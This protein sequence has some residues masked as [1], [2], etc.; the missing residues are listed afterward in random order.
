[1]P[2]ENRAIESLMRPNS[3]FLSAAAQNNH[4]KLRPI[5]NWFANQLELP[6]GLKERSHDQTIDLCLKDEETRKQVVQ[7]LAAADLGIVEMDVKEE[8]LAPETSAFRQKF[9]AL[10]KELDPQFSSNPTKKAP[11]NIPPP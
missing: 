5:F 4:E 3:L 2:G 9:D 6:S 1:M 8:E 11:V 7:L 10:L